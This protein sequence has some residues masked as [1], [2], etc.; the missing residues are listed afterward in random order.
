MPVCPL[1]WRPPGSAEEGCPPHH[2]LERRVWMKKEKKYFKRMCSK[3]RRE[4]HFFN[5]RIHIF[6][7]KYSNTFVSSRPSRLRTS[8]VIMCVAWKR[9]KRKNKFKLRLSIN[10]RHRWPKAWRIFCTE[11]ALKQKA[12]I[13]V[14]RRSRSSFSTSS[15]SAAFVFHSSSFIWRAAAPCE[16]HREVLLAA[17]RSLIVHG[18]SLS[19]SAS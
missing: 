16:P 9:R 8:A 11:A 14:P 13:T 17:P 7:A 12:A 6:P 10:A 15:F 18:K 3:E 2:T 19:P 4:R 5:W 1:H